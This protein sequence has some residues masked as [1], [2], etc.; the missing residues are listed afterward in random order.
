MTLMQSKAL[1]AGV[2]IALTGGLAM[3]A[4]ALDQIKPGSKA[5][6]FS[7]QGTDGKTHTLKSLTNKGPVVLYFIKIGCP[8]NH[9]AAPHFKNIHETY[10]G[11]GNLVGVING[12]VAAAKAWQREYNVKFPILADQSMKI[13]RGYGAEHSPWA[14]AIEG[15]KVSHV[16]PG[17]SPK[18]LKALNEGMAKMAGRKP[19]NLKWD[20][21]PAGGG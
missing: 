15:G 10:A 9:R 20:G 18:E 12:D 14:V 17:G 3:K 1:F 19:A 8:V 5:F 13:I 21:A 16:L 6:D 11:K 7:A 2:A 4:I